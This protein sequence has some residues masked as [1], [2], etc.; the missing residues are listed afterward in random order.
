MLAV[1]AFATGSF[2]RA[3]KPLQD[4]DLASLNADMLQNQHAEHDAHGELG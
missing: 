1:A 2:G 3:L 4:R